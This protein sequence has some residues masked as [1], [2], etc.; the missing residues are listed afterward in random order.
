MTDGSPDAE[1]IRRHLTG[2]RR[3]VLAIVANHGPISLDDIAIEW[4]RQH[5]TISRRHRFALPRMSGQ[6]L[7]RLE[8][9]GWVARRGDQYLLTAEGRRVHD[10]IAI[11]SE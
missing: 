6:V 4:A 5:L 11:A 2:V 3:T 9:L 1:F 8:N 10:G 7:W